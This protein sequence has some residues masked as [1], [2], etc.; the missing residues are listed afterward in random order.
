MMQPHGVAGSVLV[1][2]SVSFTGVS[3]Q[4]S[5]MNGDFELWQSHTIEIPD[6]WHPLNTN[7]Q[8]TGV[9]QTADA[10]DGNFALELKTFLG[11]R[12]NQ[13]A[14]QPGAIS[15]GY[16]PPNCNGSCAELGGYPFTNKKDT[17]VFFYKYSPSGS[18]NAFVNL[19]FKKNGSPLE[20]VSITLSA[21]ATYQYKELPFNLSQNPDTVIVNIGSS[22][23]ENSDLSF[24]G[25]DLIID[26]IG[27]KS[28]GIPTSINNLT[29]DYYNSITVFP[30]PSKGR[31][32]VRSS[33]FDIHKLEI[34]DALGKVVYSGSDFNQPVS[35]DIDISRFGSGI[36]YVKVY[37]GLKTYAKKI[38][39]Q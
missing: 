13:P 17:L 39:I 29:V 7:F 6:Q 1:L 24:V 3:S 5:L 31:F 14:A 28:K 38:M 8:E 36:Y 23:W 25:S 19:L 30:N 15:T 22:F 37:D 32:Q 9:Y 27:F 20:P 21:S 35:N 26:E 10:Y 12:E 34:Y 11:N 4:P 18:D 33:K 2:D 16:F